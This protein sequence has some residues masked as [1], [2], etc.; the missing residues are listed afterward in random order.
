MG[1]LILKSKKLSL[2][3]EKPSSN[4]DKL[5]YDT[6]LKEK[7]ENTEI[8]ALNIVLK[9]QE[10][11]KTEL[12]KD[13]WIN[14]NEFLPPYTTDTIVL[15]D[16]DYM[17]GGTRLLY[18]SYSFLQHYLLEKYFYTFK[19]RPFLKNITHFMILSVPK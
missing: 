16:E 2:Q 9:I 7:K 8:E 3:K 18:T 17:G 11:L 4:I 6:L 14:I 19:E 1:K 5:F 10:Q 12:K 15:Y 13:K